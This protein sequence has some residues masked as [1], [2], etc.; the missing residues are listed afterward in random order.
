MFWFIGCVYVTLQTTTCSSPVKAETEAECRMLEQAYVATAEA[1]N[2][3]TRVR[4][5]CV[6]ATP[7][8]AAKP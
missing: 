6:A 3:S 1:V 4:T 8:A 2:S 5:R 7:S